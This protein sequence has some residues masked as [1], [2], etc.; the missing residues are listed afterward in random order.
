VVA[1]ALSRKERVK[2][3]RTRATSITIQASLKDQIIRVQAEALEDDNSPAEL[4]RN[5]KEVLTVA[6]DG[7]YYFM[8]LDPGFRRIKES[9]HG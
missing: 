4:L 6:T 2:P 3:L 5:M 7:A 9:N 8:Y 1:D